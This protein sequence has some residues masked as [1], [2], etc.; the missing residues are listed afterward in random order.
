MIPSTK[1]VL[2]G[3]EGI[4]ISDIDTKWPVMNPLTITETLTSPFTI[5]ATTLKR[6]SMHPYSSYLQSIKFPSYSYSTGAW[7]PG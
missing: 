4:F 7:V 5:H 6:N 2:I 1:Y 3:G